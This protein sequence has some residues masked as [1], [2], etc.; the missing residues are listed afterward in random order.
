VSNERK[1]ER[2]KEDQKNFFT[3]QMAKW[4][5]SGVLSRLRDILPPTFF[6]L[7]Y[8]IPLFL[9][10]YL[11]DV[12]MRSILGCLPNIVRYGTLKKKKIRKGPQKQ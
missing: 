2:E 10:G 3:R 7:F 12:L 8:H 11:I 5:P 4:T 1:R 9:D 6:I